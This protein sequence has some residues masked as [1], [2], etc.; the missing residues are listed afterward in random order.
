MP[1]RFPGTVLKEPLLLVM[2]FTKALAEPQCLALFWIP[3]GPF[4]SDSGR[5]VG[6]KE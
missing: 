1:S 3:A 5:S 4:P 6:G 2:A